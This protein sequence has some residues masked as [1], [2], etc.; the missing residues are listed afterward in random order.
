M[1]MA[2]VMNTTVTI[3]AETQTKSAAGLDSGPVLATV[4][5]DVPA[6]V[7]TQQPYRAMQI[8]GRYDVVKMKR[9]Y[10]ASD[11]QLT[12]TTSWIAYAGK[13]YVVT[14]SEDQ[15]GELHKFYAVDVELKQ[16]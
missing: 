4:A 9:I 10:F 15:G 12:P 3:L 16:F 2:T 5:S 8:Y 6:R 7:T 14:S 11:P 1:S 13:S